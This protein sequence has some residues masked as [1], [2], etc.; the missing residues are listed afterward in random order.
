MKHFE[1]CLWW[2]TTVDDLPLVV[3]SRNSHHHHQQVPMTH[4]WFFLVSPPPCRPPPP[5]TSHYVW[6]VVPP[7]S[8]SQIQW[9]WFFIFM[10]LLLPTLHLLLSLPNGS[11]QG[12]Q[13]LLLCVYQRYLLQSVVNYM[14]FSHSWCRICWWKCLL[15]LHMATSRAFISLWQVW[16]KKTWNAD[17]ISQVVQHVLLLP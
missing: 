5:P 2:N 3:R 4:W 9:K 1:A 16:R 7:F 8:R 10:T 11:Y 13:D 14:G 12:F 15:D 6:L 17:L